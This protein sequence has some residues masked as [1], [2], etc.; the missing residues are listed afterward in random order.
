VNGSKLGSVRK[1]LIDPTAERPGTLAEGWLDLERAA[2]VEVTSEDND[3]PVESVFGSEDARGWRAAGPGSQTIRLIFDRPQRL[4]CVSLV[5][6]EAETARTQEFVLRCFSDGGGTLNEIV[7][8][9]WNFS[10][11]ESIREVE[12]Y[13]V[14]LYNV[15]ILELV[16]KP[17][18]GGGAAC[19]SL[20]NLRLS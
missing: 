14:D 3:F 2:V 7:R 17:E 4:K 1:R 12:Q 11:P 16:I 6:E 13:R 10:P 9:Q 20:K 8:Q 18:I 5:F 19:A 15:E